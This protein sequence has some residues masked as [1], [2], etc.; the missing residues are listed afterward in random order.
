MFK[1]A[2][3]LKIPFINRTIPAGTTVR[4]VGSFETVIDKDKVKLK[5][6]RPG[7]TDVDGPTVSP[8]DIYCVDEG[9]VMNVY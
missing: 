1:I 3:N 8:G 4:V 2:D 7:K 6:V 5:I 9:K